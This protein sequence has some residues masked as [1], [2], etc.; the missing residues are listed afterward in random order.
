MTKDKSPYIRPE[1]LNFGPYTQDDLRAIVR[2]G[3]ENMWLS[4]KAEILQEI[5]ADLVKRAVGEHW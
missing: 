1:D 5:T 3:L 4:G 2:R